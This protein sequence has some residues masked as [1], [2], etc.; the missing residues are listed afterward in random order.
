[1]MKIENT[2]FIGWFDEDDNEQ[3]VIDE[4]EID[5]FC[6]RLDYRNNV[7]NV[8]RNCIDVI[9]ELIFVYSQNEKLSSDEISDRINKLI[10][11]MEIEYNGNF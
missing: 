3:D 10:N 9:E 2:N 7:S 6:L 1:M 11:T 8:F 5:E 4:I